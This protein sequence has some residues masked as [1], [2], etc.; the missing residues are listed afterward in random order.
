MFPWFNTSLP[1]GARVTALVA[2]MN[3]T[4]LIS[5][6]VK[7]SP[8]V[9]R[10]GIPVGAPIVATIDVCVCVCV[11]T[12][13]RFSHTCGFAGLHRDTRGI[14]RRRTGSLR[15]DP[16]PSSLAQSGV[17]HHGTPRSRPK[18]PGRSGSKLELSGMYSYR[19]AFAVCRRINR[20]GYRLGFVRYTWL[21]LRFCLHVA[22]RQLPAVRALYLSRP[23]FAVAW[24]NSWL[25]HGRSIAHNIR[26]GDEP[27]PRPTMG[28]M[29]GVERSGPTPNSPLLLRHPELLKDL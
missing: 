18:S 11:C 17:Q 6:L 7:Y 5:Q 23:P 15:G 21:T 26:P 28:K 8:P 27:L 3:S 9:P 25:P 19:C 13:A 20:V 1:L 22:A 4:E 12:A 2:A 16:R 29:P 10:L 14:W 24:R